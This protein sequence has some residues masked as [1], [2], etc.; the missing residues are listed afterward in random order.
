MLVHA[1]DTSDVT[2]DS[3]GLAISLFG[4]VAGSLASN[5]VK[6]RVEAYT[7]NASATSPGLIDIGRIP[8]TTSIRW[9]WH[10]PLL[11][12]SAGLHR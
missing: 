12:S 1:E 9:L 4:G 6:N 2:A 8:R 7:D 5:T 10:S 11:A 3:A